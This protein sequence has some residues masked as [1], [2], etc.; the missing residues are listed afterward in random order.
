[1]QP[2]KVCRRVACTLLLLA[3][4]AAARGQE[5]WQPSTR[6]GDLAFLGFNT[7]LGGLTAGL[8]A[9]LQGRDVSDAALRGA[10]GGAVVYGG[11]RLVVADAPAAGL[12]GRQVAAVG[13]SMVRNAGA[14]RP[15]LERVVLPLPF[16]RL[17]VNVP[18]ARLDAARINLS[19][20]AMLAW[21]ATRP[22][23]TLD[24]G[25]TFAAGT[26]VFDAPDHLLRVHGDYVGG[27]MANGTVL[28]GR[29][30]AEHRRG[31]LAHELVHVLQHDFA[32]ATIGA[33]LESRLLRL[34]TV[35]RRF[36]RFLETGL[37]ALVV[38]I[39][40]YPAHEVE[41]SFLDSR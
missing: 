6:T 15:A 14:G 26:P 40:A 19:E 4:P 27:V 29:V 28:L 34:H 11:K 23:T 24:W 9:R 41:A 39:V 12:V 37:T 35:G 18:E 20:A 13:S 7:L 17:V 2:G 33:P 21:L 8:T 22:E 10:L 31:L 5:P 3:L 16:V 25:A 30:D 36:D 38:S 1:M 32:H